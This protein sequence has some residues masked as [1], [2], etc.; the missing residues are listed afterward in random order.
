MRRAGMLVLVLMCFV[1]AAVAHAGT[2]E[3]WSCAGPNGEPLPADGWRP[4]AA[5][6]FSSNVNA[7]AVRRR[8]VLRAQRRLR[9]SVRHADVVALRRAGRARASRATGSGAPRPSGR[10]CRS[11][12]RSTRWRAGR[13]S[14][15]A[16]TLRENCPGNGCSGQ[17]STSAPLGAGNL[18]TEDNLAGVR[19]LWLNAS[20]GGGAGSACRA[21]TGSGPYTVAF[22]MYRAAIVL[23]DDVDPVFTT[24]PAGHAA[25][26]GGPLAGA[27]G[28][29]FAATDA[30]GGLQEA[31][32]EVDGQRAAARQPRLRAA[33]HRRR[34]VQARGLGNGHARH[35]R[36]SPT[37]PTACACSSPTRAATA[38]PSGR[39]R[40]RRPTR[41]RA[42]R[43]RT[44]RT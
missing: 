3:V 27:H 6:A 20:C 11:R 38:R 36:R 18:V 44:P 29:S 9:P 26:A 16:P 7:C 17:G 10:A 30:G 21:A 42:A 43:P 19:D 13:T 41:R 5:R 31:V 32:L 35:G 2:Y 22:W 28:V 14:T 40:S 23:R 39:S 24:P 8:A 25:R 12:R 37:A 15:T 34:A 4:R 33:V 1:P